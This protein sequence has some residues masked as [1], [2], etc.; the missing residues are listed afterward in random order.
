MRALPFE[1][2]PSLVFERDGDFLIDRTTFDPVS[3]RASTERT[4]IRSGRTRR[5]RWSVRMFVASELRDW[6][7]RAGF[8]SVEFFDEGGEPMTASSRRMLAVARA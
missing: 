5:F 6:L 7:L 4:I 1:D 3:G 8:A 2:G